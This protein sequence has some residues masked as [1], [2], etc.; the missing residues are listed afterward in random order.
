MESTVR[1]IAI[2]RTRRGDWNTR[3]IEKNIKHG[4]NSARFRRGR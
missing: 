3:D 1:A 4:A 2:Y